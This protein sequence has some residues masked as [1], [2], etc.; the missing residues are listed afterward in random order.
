MI[1]YMYLLLPIQV[2]SFEHSSQVK[3]EFGRFCGFFF[4]YQSLASACWSVALFYFFSGEAAAVP[5]HPNVVFVHT[6][7]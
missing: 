1:Y 7:L 2:R 3:T 5:G 6:N 4:F